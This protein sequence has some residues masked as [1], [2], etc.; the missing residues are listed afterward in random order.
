MD[1]YER[2]SADITHMLRCEKAKIDGT[3]PPQQT[4]QPA[5]KP[6]TTTHSL[7]TSKVPTVDVALSL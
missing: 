6:T 7:T 5:K 3:P 2:I 4:A 1:A